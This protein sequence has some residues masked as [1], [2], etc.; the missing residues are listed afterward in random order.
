MF[1]EGSAFMTVV[2]NFGTGNPPPVWCFQIHGWCAGAERWVQR[3]GCSSTKTWY[4][5][6]HHGISPPDKAYANQTERLWLAAWH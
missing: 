1:E 2:R 6:S 3:D 4:R 5:T